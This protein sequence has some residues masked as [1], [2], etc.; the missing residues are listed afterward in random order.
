MTARGRR[1]APA[2]EPSESVELVV[3]GMSCGGCA[4]SVDKALR[5]VAGVRD[6][7]VDL[8][9]ARARVRGERL[10][11]AALVRVVVDAGYDAR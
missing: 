8:A 9:G 6:V 2:M 5:G 3:E 4:A 10:D 7:Q 1:Y 11:R